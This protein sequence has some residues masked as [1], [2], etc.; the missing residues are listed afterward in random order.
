M[1]LEPSSG[2]VAPITT[3][4]TGNV[5]AAPVV[6]DEHLYVKGV[7]SGLKTTPGPYNNKV[8]LYGVPASAV[9]YWRE[10]FDKDEKIV[11]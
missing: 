7:G 1:S 6:D 4:N 2:T 10:V 11:N 8:T 3:V 9:K 5:L